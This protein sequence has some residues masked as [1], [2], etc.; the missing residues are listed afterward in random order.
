M[1]AN[2]FHSRYMTILGLVI[3]EIDKI[4]RGVM[5]KNNK[6][7]LKRESDVLK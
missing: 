7:F 2:N 1:L 3:N 4:N 6:C 5:T